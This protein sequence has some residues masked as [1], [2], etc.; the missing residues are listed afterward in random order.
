MDLLKKLCKY[1]IITL[2]ILFVCSFVVLVDKFHK[3]EYDVFDV[4][5]TYKALRMD[6]RYGILKP[7]KA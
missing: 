3:I 6:G 1:F 2:A 5:E 4:L 7:T